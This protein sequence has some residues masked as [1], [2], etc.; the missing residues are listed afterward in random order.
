MGK[1]SRESSISVKETFD[2]YTVIE[3]NG[4]QYVVF[5]E[6][7]SLSRMFEIPEYTCEI[8]HNYQNQAMLN[9]ENIRSG[10]ILLRQEVNPARYRNVEEWMVDVQ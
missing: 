8:I 4:R 6:D 5:D 10:E 7:K 1:R 3:W 9:I 2:K